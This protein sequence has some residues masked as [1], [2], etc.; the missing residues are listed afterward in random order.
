MEK[1][2]VTGMG[3]ICSVG[4]NLRQIWDNLL[5]GVPGIGTISLFNPEDLQPLIFHQ[6]KFVAGIDINILRQ[7]LLKKPYLNQ[8]CPLQKRILRELAS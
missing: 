7:L 2:L 3:A 8:D 5:N 6:K 1:I 4:N